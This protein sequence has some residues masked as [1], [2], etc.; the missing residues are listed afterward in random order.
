[1]F[2]CVSGMQPGTQ[3]LLDVFRATAIPREQAWIR[4]LNTGY[5]RGF[6]LEV[7]QGSPV[8]QQRRLQRKKQHGEWTQVPIRQPPRTT[9]KEEPDY[10]RTEAG[11]HFS[12]KPGQW[13]GIRRQLATIG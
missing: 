3:E 11:L 10:W 5:P 6:N 2:S 8:T 9:E 13:A 12:K 1:M 4:L 7:H